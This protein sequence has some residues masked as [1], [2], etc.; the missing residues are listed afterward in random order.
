VEDEVEKAFEEERQRSGVV[1]FPVCLDDAVMETK[2]ASV[3][4]V[5]VRRRPAPR[6]DGVATPVGL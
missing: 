3:P 1:L 4:L 5:K 6:P 2:E